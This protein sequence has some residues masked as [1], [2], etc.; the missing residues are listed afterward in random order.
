MK[1]QTLLFT[2]FLYTG[3][4]VAQ[5]AGH[6]HAH[7]RLIQFPDIPGYKT[8]KCD[9][10]IH[11]VFSDGDVWP[12]IRVEEALKD[13][14]DAISM[15][16]H[17]EYQPHKDDIPHPDRNR[18]YEI[19]RKFAEAYD[20]IVVRG[21]EITRSMPPGHFNAIFIEDANK[22]QIE[23]P[24]E[25]FREARRQGAY[26]FWNHPNWVAQRPDGITKMDDLHVQMLRE[27][28]FQGIEVVNDLT[29]S[30]EALQLAIEN[31]LTIMGTSDIHGLIDWQYKVPE[32]GHR[33]VSLVMATEKSAAAIKEAMLAGRT[34]AWF[35][36]L[37]IG[38]ETLLKP[39][40]EASLRIKSAQY[41]G[42]TSV[43]TIEI[44]NVSDADYWLQNLSPYTLHA[45]SDIV[46]LK[47]HETTTLEVKVLERKA[48]VE[49]PFRVLNGIIAPNLH[50]V[51]QL[52]IKME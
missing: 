42:K 48:S 11:T 35:N 16:D 5:D 15:T 9:F 17:I 24:L 23:D 14:L 7:G 50:P 34:V 3:L 1:K 44:E 36:N 29:Y 39:L 45:H 49:L 2:A 28:L 37:L 51:I 10:H 38:R 41:P 20:L 4:M 8:L 21:A 27:G 40:I 31:N 18:S 25:A 32:G 22:L 43:A 52:T 26:V 47:A 12:T 13:G 33:P 6:G 30:D 19:A 46:T